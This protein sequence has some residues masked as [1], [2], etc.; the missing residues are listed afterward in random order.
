MNIKIPRISPAH[1][2]CISASALIAYQCAEDIF[3][4]K[5]FRKAIKVFS[6]FSTFLLPCLE[7][8]KAKKY[9][10]FFEKK[11]VVVLIN[12][13]LTTHSLST[14]ANK[15]FYLA[16]VSNVI[17]FL[18]FCRRYNISK[19]NFSLLINEKSILTH[20]QTI[21]P[22]IH[23][24]SRKPN[25][26]QETISTLLK[27][28]WKQLNEQPKNIFLWSLHAI[29]NFTSQKNRPE[30]ELERTISKVFRHYNVDN[31]SF[32]RVAP[33]TLS[34]L[35]VAKSPNQK[36]DIA[37][38]FITTCS[39]LFKENPGIV[40]LYLSFVGYIVSEYDYAFAQKAR[41]I[42]E[43]ASKEKSQ[44]ILLSLNEL[45]NE[46]PFL[47][48]PSKRSY[49]TNLLHLFSAAISAHSFLFSSSR[50]LDFFTNVMLAAERHKKRFKTCV[51]ITEKDGSNRSSLQIL[52]SDG[53]YI[54]ILDR[55]EGYLEP[56]VFGDYPFNDE[57]RSLL[58]KINAFKRSHQPALMIN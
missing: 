36:D 10:G 1:A 18:F 6:L 46:K 44:H 33:I 37:K 22:Q 39:S 25:L 27:L 11:Q 21:L 17:C 30:K 35:S 32:C 58:E 38:Y 45:L 14:K 2:F 15:P 23:K 41:E 53:A 5:S 50:C 34:A 3:I 29:V 43:R 28:I 54:Q 19:N 8:A 16:C 4:N 48:K 13:A 9:Y 42:L 40:A 51:D 20:H 31:E 26:P 7:I 49:K 24:I 57:K 52:T 55:I 12:F 47:F 56:T